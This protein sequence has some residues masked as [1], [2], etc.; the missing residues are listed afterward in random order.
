MTGCA[1]TAT[2]TPEAVRNV[3]LTYAWNF[4]CSITNDPID[5]SDRCL[6]QKT[7]VLAY[8]AEGDV[9]T[10]RACAVKIED[11]S[12]GVALA[13]VAEWFASHG[14]TAKAEA[15]AR[16]T[17]HETGID[18]ASKPLGVAR[19][20]ALETGVENIEYREVSAEV[21]AAQRPA[22]FDVVTCMELLEH[23]PE[24]ASV[25]QARAALVEG[26]DYIG[27]GPLFA[28]PTKAGRP[29]IGLQDIAAMEREVG[30]HIPAFCI[31]GVKRSNLTCVLAAG[32]RRVVIVSD[33][34]LARD[35]LAATREARAMIQPGVAGSP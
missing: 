1:P 20:H 25:V 8:L 21:L 31:G 27:F 19:L 23:V 17:A 33:L 24:P 10:A 15:M 28:T 3:P 6:A 2:K 32:T 14:E 35:V 11:W 34:L 13:A 7:V 9:E 18:L 22:A 26:F 16:R 12:R 29:A 4:A 30:R 5:Q